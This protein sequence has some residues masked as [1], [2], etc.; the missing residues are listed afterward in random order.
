[1][2]FLGG[3]NS[4]FVSF[5]LSYLRTPS[6]SFGLCA[7]PRFPSPK[8]IRGDR[9]YIFAHSYIDDSGFGY[10]QTVTAVIG[11]LNTS[12]VALCGF[13]PVLEHSFPHILPFVK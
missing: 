5:F 13:G 3:G 12:Q 9:L 4:L 7:Q 6:S 10:I 2:H 1:M 8:L 11:V